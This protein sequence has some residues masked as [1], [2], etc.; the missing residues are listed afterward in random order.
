MLLRDPS[1]FN[2]PEEFDRGSCPEEFPL[3]RILEESPRFSWPEELF[4]TRFPEDPPPLSNFECDSCL[5]SLP[6]EF[7]LRSFDE[8]EFPRK[9]WLDESLLTKS[10]REL[11]LFKLWEELDL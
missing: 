2:K 8:D 4:L 11:S 5:G 1:L 6:L 3:T 10:L 7:S 9:S